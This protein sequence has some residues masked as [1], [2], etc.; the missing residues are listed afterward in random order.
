MPKQYKK[1]QLKP[2]GVSNRNRGLE[3]IR[4]N[5]VDGVFYFA[6]DDNTYDLEIFNQ[7]RYTKKVAMWPVGLVTGYGM[8]SPI[9]RNGS[10]AG[11]YDGWIGGR[12]YPVDMAGFA[13]SVKFLL[14]R[15]KAI[16]PFDA[17]YEEDKFLKSLAPLN[18]TEIEFLA[19]G[20]TEVSEF[21]LRPFIELPLHYVS[22]F[23]T[24]NCVCLSFVFIIEFSPFILRF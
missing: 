3:W 22:R 1:R 17:G 4:K 18:E 23:I 21:V 14:S 20:C 19:S 7:M 24:I 10:F 8:S 9:I 5:A 16:M 11:F 2:R 12:K 15:P 6:D 13:V